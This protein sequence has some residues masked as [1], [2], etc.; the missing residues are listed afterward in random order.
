MRAFDGEGACPGAVS[1]RSRRDGVW[2]V[3]TSALRETL[4]PMTTQPPRTWRVGD[5]ALVHRERVTV[6][7]FIDHGGPGPL[8]EV[9]VEFVASGEERVIP[10]DSLCP[11]PD[12]VQGVRATGEVY[13]ASGRLDPAESLAV[14]VHSPEGF[15]WGNAGA[16][17]TQLALALLLRTTDRESALAHQ[18]AFTWQVIAQLPQAD[19][20]LPV[21]AV[22]GWL[23][24]RRGN[25]ITR[26]SRHGECMD[27]MRRLWVGADP[28]GRGAFGLAFI[29][30]SGAVR[31][32]TVSSVDEAVKVITATG[33][34]LG[35]GI[36]APMWWSAC[37][38][39]GR[40][41]DARLRARYGISGGTVQSGNS[42]RG[43]A[44]IGGALLASRLREVFSD[45]QITESHPKALLR[46]L[47]VDEARFAARF[48]TE[49]RW[50][51]EHERDAAIAAVCA[52]EGF[53][54][55]W[56]TD[57]T[58]QRDRSEQNPCA[59][60]LAPMAYFWP[61]AV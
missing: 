58:E 2:T 41:A 15:W 51:N 40:R 31:C 8:D 43:A 24:S 61:E 22:H 55:R 20:E 53:E 12:L 44:L 46:A 11:L 9:L 57:L 16:G 23:A 39:G 6:R 10:R 47:D 59:Y 34:P 3:V 18:A 45:L 28:G 32:E 37:E 25:A 29:D 56:A 52:R 1:A 42:L 5:Q 60:W 21:T 27:K 54:G 49:T 17:A 19:F 26:L 48:R 36:D 4:S 50:N 14:A 33:Y 13:F 7:G 38:G 30:V 35:L